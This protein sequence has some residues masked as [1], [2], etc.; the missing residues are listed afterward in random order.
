MSL[1]E[2]VL[3]QVEQLGD[4]LFFKSYLSEY[5]YS[6]VELNSTMRVISMTDFFEFGT[7]KSHIENLIYCFDLLELQQMEC[8][9]DKSDCIICDMKSISSPLLEDGVKVN[10]VVLLSEIMKH[11]HL[12]EIAKEKQHGSPY[13]TYYMTFIVYCINSVQMTLERTFEGEGDVHI[14]KS[15]IDKLVALPYEVG[16]ATATLLEMI[17][18][19]EIKSKSVLKNYNRKQKPA[20]KRWA[21]VLRT[22]EECGMDIY[23]LDT[24]PMDCANLILSKNSQITLSDY[25]IRDRIQAL[26]RGEV[27]KN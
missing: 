21:M 26:R 9:C 13:I 3:K 5:E 25:T 19:G 1:R 4:E 27:S 11:L 22:A 6:L 18:D 15:V 24:S 12:K 23:C 14:C 2:S 8:N 16:F 10:L 17:K 20:E 7:P